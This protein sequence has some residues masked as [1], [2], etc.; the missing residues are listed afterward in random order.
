MTK[1]SFTQKVIAFLKGGEEAKM[2]RFSSKLSKYISKQKSMRL[3]KIETLRDK[4]ADANEV[5]EETILNVNLD[6]VN[7]TEGVEGYIPSYLRGIQQAKGTIE[8]Y[9]SEIE[10]LESEIKEFEDLETL[11]FEK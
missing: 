4:I 7:K 5:L 3:E 10:Q 6:S 1:L 8:A 2:E 11:I 9:E